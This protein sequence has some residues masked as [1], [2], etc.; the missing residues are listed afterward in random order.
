[1]VDAQTGETLAGAVVSIKG[2]V[3][4]LLAD[5]N[6]LV[7]LGKAVPA[8]SDSVRLVVSYNGYRALETSA[9]AATRTG[10]LRLEPADILLDAVVVSASRTSEKWL[11]S[12]AP[13]QK[14]TLAELGRS[15]A[16]NTFQAL[17][18][19]AGLDLTSSS[20]TLQ[21]LNSRGFSLPNNLRFVQ[22]I[23]GMEMIG[24]GIG[25]QMGSFAAF[26]DL[27]FES[28][29]VINGPASSLYGPNAFNGVSSIT[30][31]DPFEYPG[32][33]ANV[34]TGFNLTG[35]AGTT[36]YPL[37]EAAVR[38]ARPVNNRLAF[39]LTASVLRATDWW[40]T[41]TADMTDYSRYPPLPQGLV[42]NGTNVY[43]DEF[44]GRFG[45][46]PVARTGYPEMQLRD[47]GLSL[48]NASASVVYRL[49]PETRLTVLGRFAVGTGVYLADARYYLNNFQYHQAKA[50]LTGKHY[51]VRAYLNA[52]NAGPRSSNFNRL[53]L[54]L[55]QS[56]RSDSAWGQV[57]TRAFAGEYNQALAALGLPAV[58]PGDAQAARQLA[59][60]NTDLLRNYYSQ[61]GQLQRALELA[62]GPRLQ[63]GTPEFDAALD[64]FTGRNV[65]E[66][67]ANIDL[68]SQVYTTEAQYD[69]RH[70]VPWLDL[71][72]G[73]SFRLQNV[74]SDN[75]IFYNDRNGRIGYETGLY[76][77]A[78]RNFW[79][80]RLRLT[81]SARL[82]QSW[83]TAVQV[84]PRL[85]ASLALDAARSRFVRVNLQTAFRNPSLQSAYLNSE[86]IFNTRFLG[87]AREVADAFG[88]TRSAY[89]LASVFEYQARA[90]AGDPTAEAALVRY[91]YRDIRP[92]RVQTLDIGFRGKLMPRL[93]ADFGYYLNRYVDLFEGRAF[94]APLTANLP[95]DLP[96]TPAQL[97][98][99]QFSTIGIEAN[100]SRIVYS[101]GVTLIAAYDLTRHWLVSANYSYNALLSES[102]NELGAFNTP[103]HKLNAAVTATDLFDRLGFQL[104][105][106]YNGAYDFSFAALRGQVPAYVVVDAQVQ[107]RLPAFRSTVRLGATNLLNSQHIEVIGGPNIGTTVYVQ[108]HFDS[109]LQR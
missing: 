79:Q 39:K 57:F 11:A 38:Y 74:T 52:E 99:G 88:L 10:T 64:R 24:P 58:A 92:E 8:L 100:S 16:F 34:K 73:G 28:V 81:G 107:Y 31:R 25:L 43:G 47:K 45:G 44:V 68:R 22:R 71:Q 35:A 67:G 42:Y 97:L 19:V 29:E 5:D 4:G 26:N 32:L 84:S 7:D 91:E 40:A 41:N 37:V 23:D 65:S 3:Q 17:A 1:V 33:S 56:A 102:G 21:N 94:A 51:F 53:A 83:L 30:T 46:L 70:L 63:P 101:H 90:A 75:T 103:N 20:F 106:R 66:G 87:A 93:R 15:P 89:T 36:P 61:T 76:L 13:V 59:D 86:Y 12:P 77:Q 95:N 2:T 105:A 54:L 55:N 6:G 14:L 108:V 98:D 85:G 82:D 104:S 60:G 49:T 48:A 69:F 62:G 109:F 72:A 80:E 96:L 78:G 27:D 50:E 18:N 9:A